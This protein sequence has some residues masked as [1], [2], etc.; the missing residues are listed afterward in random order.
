MTAPVTQ[1]T[2]NTAS[3]E[4]V[5]KATGLVKTFGRVIGLDGVDMH[6]HAGEIL[7]IIGDNGAGKS[8]LIKC[9]TGADVP[10][11]GEIWL[12]G[13]IVS[14]KRPQDARAMGIETVYQTLA[15]APALDIA[16]NLYLGRER[17]RPGPL[18]SVLRMMDKKG[19]KESAGKSIQ[20]LGI[21]TIQDMRE[22][23]ESLSGGQRQA[24]AV[25]RA[26]A[27]GSKVVFLDEP[28]AALGVKESNAVLDMIRKLRDAN[29]AVVLVSH[30]MPQVFEVADRI[31]IQRLGGSA[32]VITPR[33]HTMSEAVAI[34]TGATTL[35]ET[36]GKPD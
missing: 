17:R 3:T 25:A 34:M 9:L 27:F 14:F 19:M 5:L 26:A 15:I 13:R 21:R 8:T 30:N 33:S 29:L 36:P 12:D 11:A 10:D 16:S 35:E 7:A 20:E 28:T 32:G 22:A 18:G 23:V 31:H 4:P 2:T 24:V 6:V 1:P